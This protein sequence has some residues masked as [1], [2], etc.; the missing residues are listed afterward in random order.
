MLNVYTGFF[1]FVSRSRVDFLDHRFDYE[2]TSDRKTTD[3]LDAAGPR[4]PGAHHRRDQVP[5]FVRIR[6]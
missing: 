4:A 2:P 5:P 6:P 1:D 3:H